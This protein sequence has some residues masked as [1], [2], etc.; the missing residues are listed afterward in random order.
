MKF[1]RCE[2]AHGNQSLVNLNYVSVVSR[3]EYGDCVLVNTGGDYTEWADVIPNH[4]GD[5]VFED[6]IVDI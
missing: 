3:R 2:S 1:V 5:R 4:D 6:A